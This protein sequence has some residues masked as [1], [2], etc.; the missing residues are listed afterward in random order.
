MND[1]TVHHNLLRSV[2]QVLNRRAITA[3]SALTL[4]DGW[5]KAHDDLPAVVRADKTWKPAMYNALCSAVASQIDQDH[6][7]QQANKLGQQ[8]LQLVATVSR[9]LVSAPKAGPAQ[10]RPAMLTVCAD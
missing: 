7:A 3:L 4:P 6:R 8:Q 1:S 2:M 5:F 10:Q 9:S